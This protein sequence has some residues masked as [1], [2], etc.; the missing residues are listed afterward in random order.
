MQNGLGVA[1][2]VLLLQLLSLLL[3]VVACCRVLLFAFL[4]CRL[5]LAAV[6]CCCLPLLA[7]EGLKQEEASGQQKC[8][9]VKENCPLYNV[10]FDAIQLCT[11][12]VWAR[13]LVEPQLCRTT[14]CALLRQAAALRDDLVHAIAPKSNAEPQL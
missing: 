8:K 9:F 7:L 4:C 10:T 11:F 13:Y 6:A 2:C 3:L 1:C 14:S 5:R 12:V